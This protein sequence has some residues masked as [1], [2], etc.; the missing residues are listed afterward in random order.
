MA[1]KPWQKEHRA[2]EQAV[3]TKQ[4][5]PTLAGQSTFVATI[6]VSPSIQRSRNLT[7][8]ALQVAL[9]AALQKLVAYEPTITVSVIE[10]KS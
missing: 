6:A 10:A 5:T 3:E 1:K 2:E 4:P 8:D 9:D 7:A